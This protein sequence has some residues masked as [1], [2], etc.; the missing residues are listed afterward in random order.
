[1]IS[2]MVVIMTLA[3]IGKMVILSVVVTMMGR[4]GCNMRKERFSGC[5]A[6]VAKIQWLGK[7]P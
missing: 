7:I 3:L 4:G 6:V 2:L 1:M 5:I